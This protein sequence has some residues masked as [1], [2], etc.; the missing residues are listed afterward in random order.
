M[1]K[2]LIHLG[3][4]KTATT[5]IQ[6]FLGSNADNI[7]EY[8]YPRFLY[9]KH[10]WV[11]HSIPL[12]NLFSSNRHK[13]YWNKIL[14]LEYEDF[15]KNIAEQLNQILNRNRNII[16]SGEGLSL[17]TTEDMKKMQGYFYDRNYEVHVVAYV[18][19]PYSYFTSTLQQAIKRGACIQKFEVRIGYQKKIDAIR[20][21]FDYSEF[22]S[23][24]DICG[25]EGLGAIS[26]FLN[27][28]GIESVSSVVEEKQSN[29]SLSQFAARILSSYNFEYPLYDSDGRIVAG[30]EL[31]DLNPLHS[32]K[33]GGKFMLSSEEF[34]P[35]YDYVQDERNY[36]R[37]IGLHCDTNFDFPGGF[38]LTLEEL[39]K[40][41][42]KVDDLDLKYKNYVVTWLA[43]NTKHSLSDILNVGLV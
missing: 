4:H 13:Y 20:Q 5:S 10:S 37:S 15:A 22:F 38:N 8:T 23:F 21:A 16:L 18:R 1:N 14:N 17:L 26:H 12:Y 32:L 28:C 34:A 25:K 29:V 39:E 2:V 11:N 36:L 24:E 35:Y 30:R 31:G 33:G 9:E 41:R 40:N 3:F 7:S 27:Y 19:E 43:R 42:S 6:Q